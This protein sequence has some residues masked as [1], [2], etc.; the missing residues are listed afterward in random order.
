MTRK[1]SKNKNSKKPQQQPEKTGGSSRFIGYFVSLIVL[2]AV[3]LI[4]LSVTSY[5]PADPP[6]PGSFPPDP[7][8]N[9]AGQIGALLADL[10]RRWIGVG[11]YVMMGLMT[12]WAGKR[13]IGK[14]VDHLLWRITGL[15]LLLGTVTTAAYIIVN[16]EM[17][18]LNHANTAYGM[19]GQYCGAELLKGF[20][21][22][23]SWV[24]V[25][26]SGCIGVLFAAED[27]LRAIWKFIITSKDSQTPNWFKRTAERYQNWCNRRQDIA[28]AKRRAREQAKQDK[29]NRKEAIRAEKIAAREAA[30][31]EKL[32]RLEQRKNAAELTRRVKA[33][34]LT[35]GEIAEQTPQAIAPAPVV[36]PQI[37]ATEQAEPVAPAPAK[38]GFLTRLF[39]KKNQPPVPAQPEN[40][41]QASAQTT[42]DILPVAQQAD[43]AENQQQADS[44]KLTPA[45][46]TAKSTSQNDSELQNKSVVK[47][48]PRAV[49][50]DTKIKHKVKK[51]RTKRKSKTLPSLNLLADPIGGY[52]EAAELQAVRRKQVLQQTLDDFNVQATVEGFQTGPVITLFEVGLAPGVKT[53]AVANLSTDIARSLAV[54]GVRIV[55]PRFGKDTVGIEVPNLEKETV[56]LKE[57]MHMRA[58]AEK[59]M[60]L[61]MYLGKNAGGEAIVTDLAKCPHML[62]AGTTGSG[63]S[64]CINTIIMSL[65]LTRQSEDVRFIMVDP[66]MVE[67]AAFEKLPHLLCP[68]ITD[69]K[70]AEDILEWACVK[71]DERYEIL[72]E[73]GVKNIVGYNSLTEDQIYEK[74]GCEEE[75][76]KLRVQTRLPYYVI[77]IDELADLMMTSTK[78]VE[79]YIIRIAQK[80]RA[81]GI[82]LVLATQR[83][84]ANVVTGLI[85]SNMPCRVSFR[86]ASGQESR[87]VLDQKGAEILLGQGDMLVLQP[88]QSTLDRAQGTFVDDSEIFAVV[89][90]LEKTGEQKFDT[91]LMQLQSSTGGGLSSERDEL[92]DKAVEIVLSTKRGSVSLLQRRLS[93]GYGRSSRIIDQMAE[94][95]ILGEHKGSQARECLI[96]L[97]DWEQMKR[98]IASDISGDN[99]LDGSGTSY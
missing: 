2:G 89:S 98:G 85:K 83:P 67:M 53:A 78:E 70:K 57:L 18:P 60:H 47:H 90:E 22:L 73:V 74:L 63:K 56:R 88:G 42:A 82:H 48:S 49:V 99:S 91:S 17:P 13:L 3:V 28:T 30:H 69:M 45:K 61:P 4:W 75:E 14:R 81:V 93:I 76:D 27:A 16:P 44:V 79:S 29:L 36:Q 35:E 24:I 51:L 71:M 23:G 96:T 43:P 25:A 6:T 32:A 92:F 52:S 7:V 59:K 26:V 31:A 66:K 12:F 55:P 19:I 37:T 62:I 46:K 50:Q 10:L 39:G 33:P 87:I 11:V 20:G 54:P 68:T 97:D 8:K 9:R 77:I 38:P 40:Q 34:G 5:D 64:V 94:S 1:K 84:S 15:V 41:Q 86:V 21:K 80:A 72:K 58:D 65:L 95:G